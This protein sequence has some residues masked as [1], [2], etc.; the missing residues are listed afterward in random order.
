MRPRIRLASL[1]VVSTLLASTAGAADEITLHQVTYPEDR[2]VDVEFSRDTKA[3][4]ARVEAEV[5][6]RRGQA[7]IDLKY[8]DMKPAILFRG[9][10]TCYVLWAV[11]RGGTAENLGELWVRDPNET[12]QYSTSLKSFAMIITGESHPLVSQPSGLVLFTSSA[13]EPKRAPTETFTYASFAPAPETDY[14]AIAA[15]EWNRDENLDVQQADTVYQLAVDAGAEAYAPSLLRRARTTLAQ[16]RNLTQSTRTSDEAIDY[17]RRTVSLSG[18]AMQ[19]TAQKKEAERLAAEIAER[20]AEMAAL[21]ARAA[22]A[23]QTA[24]DA[25][26][27]LETTQE[28]R[29]VAEAAVAAATAELASLR[30]ERQQLERTVTELGE[31][32]RDLSVRLQ[33]ALAEVAETRETAR[34]TIVNLPDILFDLNEATLKDGARVVLAKL[35]GILLIMEELNLRVEGHTDSTGSADYNQRLSERRAA[36]V[37]DFL[38]QQGVAMDRMVAV[39]YGMDRPI[40][41]NE[42]TEGR[43]KNRRVEIVIAEGT[44]Q[45]APPAGR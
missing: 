19:V 41:T 40:A 36:S 11:Q 22:E 28:E 32:K 5:E 27:N 29:R 7:A 18:E 26:A 17:A 39:G 42:T 30:A 4:Q 24:A 21:E 8:R 1:I 33:G 12:L 45:E 9:E 34:G 20:Q 43:A 3:P 16:A 31:E 44:V 25:Q 2:E 35:A 10:V 38:A 13:A 23:E 14:P 37:R 15:V 6:Y